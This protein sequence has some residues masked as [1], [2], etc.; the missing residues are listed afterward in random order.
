MNTIKILL[1][2]TLLSLFTTFLQAQGRA[3][4]Q[5]QT[6]AGS[7]GGYF[8]PPSA[9]T[10]YGEGSYSNNSNNS[11]AQQAAIIAGYKNNATTINNKGVE[12]HNKGNYRA[13]ITAYKKALW[14]NPY[15]ETAKKNLETA[16]KALKYQQESKRNAAAEKLKEVEIQKAAQRERELLALQEKA[17]QADAQAKEN[18][19]KSLVNKEQKDLETN[20]KTWVDYQKEQFK[21]R[22]EQ[23]NYWCQ[24]YTNTLG[25]AEQKE[26]PPKK[27]SDLQPGDVLLFAPRAGDTAG[28]I[29]V[30]ADKFAQFH[31]NNK[32]GEGWGK[33]NVSHTITFLKEVKGKKLFLD[34][35]PGEGPVVISE[36]EMRK[37]YVGRDASVAKLQ[38]FWGVAQP[39]NEDEAKKL[40]D[41]AK[42]FQRKNAE[43]QAQNGNI[44]NVGDHTNYGAVGNN[45][46][47]CSEASWS[48]IKAA[49]REM[50]LSKSWVTRA[51]GVDFSPA[52][53]YNYQQYFLIT[54]INIENK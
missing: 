25:N 6:L 14:Y 24:N 7:S 10:P 8:P 31:G 18:E 3:L 22:I 38:D 37:R 2:I 9:P 26:I 49:G 23:P 46:M 47:V 35:M 30:E 53:F 52:D 12:S 36:D 16:R 21:R 1:S 34:N 29:V 42:E 39:L 11:A 48:L 27:L 17:V 33:S 32:W 44:P 45:N 41:K 43:K 13:A 4:G 5:L 50:P 51:T 54:N 19:L 40:W 28:E 15:D 20:T